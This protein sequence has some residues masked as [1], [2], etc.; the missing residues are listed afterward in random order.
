MTIYGLNLDGLGTDSRQAQIW[1]ALFGALYG[2]LCGLAG[3]LVVAFSN[4]WFNPDLPL[5]VNWGAF[6]LQLPLIGLGLAIVG[7]VTC[8]WHEAWQGLLS[9]AAAAAALTL[10]AALVSSQVNTGMKFI[11]LVF[12]LLPVAAMSLPISYFLRWVVEKHGRAL[13]LNARNMRIAGLVLLVVAIGAT[14]GYLMKSS[15]RA[16]QATRFIHEFLQDLSADKNPLAAVAGVPERTN[17]P[18]TMYPTSSGSSS[19]GFDVHIQYEDGYKVLCT[20]ILYPQRQPF[21]SRCSPE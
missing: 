14:C 2:L 19:E 4:I 20:V 1:R 17:T 10:I 7:A 8:W 11:V 3:V 12:I 18:Y 13:H 6:W 5:A 16:V 9:G 15:N 21:L